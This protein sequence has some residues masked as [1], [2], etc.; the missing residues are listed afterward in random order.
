M[1]YEVIEN[2]KVISI[3]EWLKNVYGDKWATVDYLE[4]G[5]VLRN[6]LEQHNGHY[7]ARP[8]KSFSINETV[9][10]ASKLNKDLVVIENL[11]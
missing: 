10:E 11:S 7:Y 5:A 3:V 8:K 2:V 1:D 6:W 4:S 9:L